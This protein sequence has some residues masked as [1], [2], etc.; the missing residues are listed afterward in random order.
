[1]VTM[2]TNLALRPLPP[3]RIRKAEHGDLAAL[4][5]L[6]QRVFATDRLSRRSLLRFLTSP[7]AE[8]LVA[9]EQGSLGGVAIVLYRSRAAVAR[10]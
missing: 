6:E 1:M 5:D 7:T 2:A 9:D 8:V 3:V 4:L 10:L